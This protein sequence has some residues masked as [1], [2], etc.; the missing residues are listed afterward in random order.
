MKA[1]ANQCETVATELEQLAQ[2]FKSI[3]EELLAV[4]MHTRNMLCYS[5]IM[6]NVYRLN[7]S[8]MLQSKS[9]RNHLKLMSYFKKNWN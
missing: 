5:L 9:V 6:Y 1:M 8:V 4:N 3:K 7:L 2:Q